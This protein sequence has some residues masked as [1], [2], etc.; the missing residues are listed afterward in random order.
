MKSADNWRTQLSVDVIPS[1]LASENQAIVYFTRR[2]LLNERTKAVV[3]VWGLPEPQKL[4]R[5]QRFNGSWDKSGVK[6]DVYPEHY[7][8]LIETFKRSRI[9]IERYEFNKNHPS[10]RNAAKYLF[11]CQTGEGDIRGFIGNQYATYYTGYALSLLIRAGYKDDPRVEN[12][13]RWLLTMRQN[14]GGWT[15]PI[16]THK[17]DKKTGN[18]LT[19]QYMEPVPPDRTKPFSHNWTD[20]VLRAYAA[21]PGYRDADEI[22]AAGELLK[23]SFFKPDAYPSYQSPKYWT[24]FVFWWPNLLTALESLARL[25]FTKNDPDIKRGLDWL[26]ENQQED[27]LWK[28]ENDKEVKAKDTE[29]RLWLGLRVCRMLKRYYD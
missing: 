27:G 28:L 18:K 6:A 8:Q 9:L 10:I 11:S 2:D 1:L 20:M 15:V 21:H 29:E 26:I 16:L 17:W 4:L 22:K 13:M 3:F 7:H 25:G 23:S 14:D 12:G 5:H 24:R 19:S